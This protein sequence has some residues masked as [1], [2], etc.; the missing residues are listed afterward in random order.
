MPRTNAM[1]MEPAS[2]PAQPPSPS[3]PGKLV[4]GPSPKPPAEQQQ[5]GETNFKGVDSTT[6]SKAGKEFSRDYFDEEP[7]DFVHALDFEYF[8]P[9]NYIKGEH[10]GMAGFIFKRRGI[11][12]YFSG[13]LL[14]N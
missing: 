5:R 8:R 12:E 7:R 1:N 11:A 3:V 9:G 14:D 6:Q 2:S 13:W 10:K 4:T